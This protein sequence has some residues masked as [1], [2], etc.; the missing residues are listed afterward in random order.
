MS[1]L[2][3]KLLLASSWS[4]T[5]TIFAFFVKPA[6]VQFMDPGTSSATPHRNWSWHSNAKHARRTSHLVLSALLTRFNGQQLQYGALADVATQHKIGRH[7]AARIWKR[8][9]ESYEKTG[10]FES[11]PTS[12]RHGAR[13]ST[14][15]RHW[16]SFATSHRTSATRSALLPVRGASPARLSFA[17]SAAAP[18]ELQR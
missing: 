8:A 15:A 6:F 4:T 18:C 11:K 13:R 10:V 1:F 17:R 7:T 2:Q 5:V 9:R 3:T 12:T 16:N 14:G